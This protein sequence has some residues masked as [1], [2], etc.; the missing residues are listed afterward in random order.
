MSDIFKYLIL[1]LLIIS[2]K[3][4]IEYGSCIDN[5]RSVRLE[6]GTTLSLQCKECQENYYTIYEND[7]LKCVKCPDHTYNYGNNITIDYFDVKILHRYLSLITL[8]CQNED[9][10]LCPKFVRNYFSIKLEN[11]N[12]KIDSKSI[13]KFKPYY[14]NDGYFRIKYINY[15]G[16]F[17][18]YLN[19]Y[20]NNELVYKDDT[21]HSKV[22]SREFKIKKGS[23]QIDIQYIVDKN[24]TQDNKDLE[25]FFE[26][27]EIEMI[28]AEVSSLECQ[29]FDEINILKNSIMDNCDYYVNKCT[30]NDF[31]TFRF[32]VEQTNGSNFIDGTQ[33]VSYQRLNGSI[34]EDFFPPIPFD[35]DAEQC[36]YGQYR[37]LTEYENLYTCGHCEENHYNDKII[38]YE[39]T[40][41][42]ICD[43]NEK[44]LKKVLYINKFED[45]SQYEMD[46][47]I[48]DMIGHIEINY[49]KYNL[50]EDTIIFYDLEEKET[51]NKKTFRLINPNINTAINDGNFL[52]KIPLKKG[53]HSFKIKG[54]NFKMKIIKVFN[55]KEG[56]NYLC[57][58]KLN[59]EEEVFCQDKEYYSRNQ[60]KCSECPKGS[61]I[62]E[63][64]RCVFT[65]EIINNKFLLENNLLLQNE[66][67]KST[68]IIDGKDNTQYHLYLYPTFPLIYS[69]KAGS[70]SE[71]IGNEF[72]NVKL[73]RGINTKG[74]ILSYTHK[75]NDF[76]YNTYLFI[77]CNKSYIQENIEFIKEEIDEKTKYFYFSIQS[78][79]TC[80]YCLESEIEE[81][82]IDKKCPESK[83]Q[84]FDIIIKNTSEC[85]IKPY[86]NNSEHKT[87][88]D[89]NSELLLFYNSSL[90]E[91]KKLI[92]NYNINEA[93][94]IYYELESDEI[95]TVTQ[96]E[97][98]CSDEG[99]DSETPEPG[100]SGG[101][102]PYVIA[103]IVLGSS[104][105]I[106]VIVIIIIKVLK[107]KRAKVEEDDVTSGESKEMKL[108]ASAFDE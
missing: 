71:I 1:S 25:T 88:I 93:I 5:K 21:K 39:F 107:A 17:N 2:S 86:L 87:I 61:F 45:Q 38:N 62:E 84:K 90:K 70:D 32:Y 68:Y 26:I 9:E 92:Q 11:I 18:K 85:V 33:T 14:M 30:E 43:V 13:L 50:K 37:N 82:A 102:K 97:K 6:N 41:Q 35:I 103:L 78:N 53:E 79:I 60:K 52:F 47:N 44:E 58:N 81:V 74:I 95:V 83:R 12:D 15:N 80:P 51:N 64:S 7:E 75:D 19:I 3:S 40:C 49:K 8:E 24:I 63:N 42:D 91:D 55:E 76:D 69:T 101:L 57:I 56:G 34:C 72:N 89:K 29:K 73:V 65:Q 98:E 106:I 54:K 16:D 108:K 104:I 10:S 77:K 22:K 67:L 105:V 36:S 99:S 4:E 66:L 59:P 100:P 46:I 31:C 94:P 28:N 23:N 27:Y 20:I 48:T 96:R